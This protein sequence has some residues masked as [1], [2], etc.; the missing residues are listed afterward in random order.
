MPPSLSL[1]PPPVLNVA[2]QGLC[3]LHEHKTAH[4]AYGDPNSVMVDMGRSSSAGFD[5]TRLSVRRY[6]RVNFSRMQELL[7]EEDLRSASF[8]RDTLAEEVST[9]P[10]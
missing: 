10:E 5:R 9:K 1:P 8:C 4:C 2:Y 6:C 3:F 7:R